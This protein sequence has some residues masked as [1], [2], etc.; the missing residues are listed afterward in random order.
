MSR[1]PRRRVPARGAHRGPRRSRPGTRTA[2]W[3]GPLLAAGVVLTLLLLSSLLPYQ[4][5]RLYSYRV[6]PAT[7]CTGGPVTAQV[8]RQFTQT[9]DYL[10]LSEQWLTVN[11]PGYAVDRPIAGNSAELPQSALRPTGRETVR[12]PLLRRAPSIPGVYRVQIIAQVQGKRWGFYPAIG[13]TTNYSENTVTVMD[14]TGRSQ[15][16]SA[17]GGNS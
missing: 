5:F 8:T 10:R 1:R 2:W 16:D 13:S 4:P 9:F 14:C 11:V 12:S 3:L 6:T 17:S 7:V 15:P